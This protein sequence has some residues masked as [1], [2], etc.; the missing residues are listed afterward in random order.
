MTSLGTLFLGIAVLSGIVSIV[1]LLW[2]RTMSH[3]EGESITN[4]G[5]LASFGVLVGTTGAVGV[6]LSAFFR[7]DFAFQYVAENHSTDVSSLSWL[8][9]ISGVWAGREGSLLFWAWLIALFGA[10]IAY[11]RIAETDAL[12]NASLAIFNVVQVFF[13]VALF[14]DTNNPFRVTSMN[15]ADAQFGLPVIDAA[16]KLLT[17]NGMNPLLQHWAMILHPPTLFIGYAGLTVP[18]AFAMGALLVGDG[19]KRWVQL[20]DRITVFSWLFLGIGIGLGAIWAYWELSFG[21]YWAWDPVENASLLPWLTGVAL[22]HSFTVYRRRGIFK[23]WAVI[24]A[25]AS[26]VLVILGTFITRSGVIDSVHAFGKDPLSLYLFAAMMILPIIATVW[27]L[28]V[29]SKEFGG[30]EEFESLTS[31]ESSYYFNN[32]FMLLSAIVVALFTLSPALTGKSLEANHYDALAHPLGIIYVGIMAICPLLSWRKTIG[33]DF[34]RRIKSSIVLTGALTVGMLTL[35]YLKLYPVLRASGSSNPWEP[36]PLR[37]FY[38]IVGLTVGALAIGV[39]CMLFIEGAK[40]RSRAK[41]EGFFTALGQILVRARTQSGG[42]L[43]HLGIGIILLGLV[44]SS[45]YVDRADGALALQEGEQFPVGHYLFVYQ[46]LIEDNRANGDVESQF[47]FAVSKDGKDLGVL[48]PN[49]TDFAKQG[50]VRATADI[51]Y[52]L[53]E[54]VFLVVNSIESGYMYVRVAIHPL[55]S[56]VWIGFFLTIVGTGL[57][58]WPKK[59]V[60]VEAPAAAGARKKRS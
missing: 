27:G 30:A 48:K 38:S 7:Q 26:F 3:S 42:Y 60:L 52:G 6:L 54:D 36:A 31:K 11:K 9:K 41:G 53:L 57:A 43:T 45:M 2:A 59:A 5:Y 20:V 49:Y 33:A 14:I 46:G 8:Y 37:I 28:S 13:L 24:Q 10:Y 40:A 1:S 21:G 29:R 16:G 32:V 39:A 50:K 56:W 15:L 12:S 55:I 35:W 18:F 22:L 44:G 4:F 51:R 58:A 17:N 25:T 19:S 34:W 23:K 47:V